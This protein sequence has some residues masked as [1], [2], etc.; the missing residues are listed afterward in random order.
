MSD[1][2]FE[3]GFPKPSLDNPMLFGQYADAIAARLRLQYSPSAGYRIAVEKQEKDPK[4]RRWD[5]NVHRGWFAGAQV[6]IKPVSGA[7]H[8]ANVEVCWHTRLMEI[9]AKTF[10]VLSVPFFILI[11]LV[12]AFT[13]RLGFALI[14]TLILWFVWALLGSIVMVLIARLAS[15]AFGNEFDQNRRSTL[16]QEIKNIALPQQAASGP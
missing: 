7:P 8:R 14:L 4:K 1:P 15:A 10:A 9:M 3:T 11:F 6:N 13:T 16:A 5:I 12:F 2:S